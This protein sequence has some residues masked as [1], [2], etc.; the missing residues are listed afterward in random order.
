[1]HEFGIMS[2]VMDN[3][4]RVAQEHDAQ[5]INQISL[6][7]GVM[8]EA[9]EESL[10]FAFDILKEDT[11]A[12]DAVLEVIEIQ[13]YSRCI[14]CGHEFEHTRYDLRCPKCDSPLTQVLKGRELEVA[15]IELDID[16]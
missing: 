13:P 4:I 16:E 14:E 15:S 10:Q 7:I 5:K 8:V 11:I 12:Q 1:M 6:R 2:S 3:V 9:V